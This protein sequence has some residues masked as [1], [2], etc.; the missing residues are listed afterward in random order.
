M[1]ERLEAL[2]R[3]NYDEEE[4]MNEADLYDV[5]DDVVVCIVAY[6]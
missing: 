6:P 5:D 2:E 4:C 3:D 1:N